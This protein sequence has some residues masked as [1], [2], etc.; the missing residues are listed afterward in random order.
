MGLLDDILVSMKKQPG[1]HYRL[2]RASDE[3]LSLKRAEGYENVTKTDPEIKGTILERNAQ[4]DGSVR[5]GN[6]VI[7]H[8]SEEQHGRLRKKVE[9]RTTAR[10]ESI[11]RNYLEEGERVKRGLGKNHKNITFVAEVKDE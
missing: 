2:T 7:Q 11:R 3:R 5:I 1:K 4:S 6:L 10:E 9:D 8:V